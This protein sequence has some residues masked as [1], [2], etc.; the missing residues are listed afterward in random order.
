MRLA[1]KSDKPPMTGAI[2]FHTKFDLPPEKGI[3]IADRLNLDGK[4]DVAHG[5]FTNP[6]VAGKIETLSRKGQGKPEDE[7][8][9]SSVSELKGNFVLD[10]GVH[11]F[12]A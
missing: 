8:A 6:Q 7:D 3:D 1:V 5:Q 9:G 12:R 2:K 11:T 4:F 10:N